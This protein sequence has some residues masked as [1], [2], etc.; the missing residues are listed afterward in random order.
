MNLLLAVVSGE[1][2]VFEFLD[3]FGNR[4]LGGDQGRV[5]MGDRALLLDASDDLINDLGELPAVSFDKV[6]FNLALIAGHGE[7]LIVHNR[8]FLPGGMFPIW[9]G[10]PR[11][12]PGIQG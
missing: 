3:D 12:F 9:C 11:T 7:F 1:K 10:A 4:F 2:E 8:S 5:E 6:D